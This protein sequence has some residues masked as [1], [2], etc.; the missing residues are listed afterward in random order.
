L[1]TSLFF[2][3]ILIFSSNLY[4]DINNDDGL[5][6]F[7]GVD[8]GF[9]N[10]NED[11]LEKRS[12]IH[13]Q[14]KADLSYYQP[15]MVFDFGFGWFYN[16]VDNA[17]VTTRTKSAFLEASARYR[18]NKKWNIGPIITAPIANDNSFASATQKN[19]SETFLGARVDF[20]P[21]FFR[22]NKVRLNAAIQRDISIS[23]RSVTFFTMGIQFGFPFK[24]EK[25][26]VVNKVVT[27]VVY[28]KKYIPSIVKVGKNRLRATF[29]RGSGFF[30]KTGSDK[31]NTVMVSY[32]E[33]LT[34]FL[35][36]YSKEWK[37]LEISGHTDDVGKFAYNMNLSKRRA[38]RVRSL[39]LSKGIP[40]HRLLAKWYGPK[41]PIDKRK[42]VAA[43]ARNRR[44]EIEFTGV[45]NIDSFYQGLSVIK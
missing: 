18:L 17:S 36:K 39:I 41:K 1:K 6:G 25:V 10:V 26:N 12:G 9:A 22:D 14:I 8:L 40:A 32:L 33:R 44:V 37:T 43:R 34:F 29:D 30:F 35:K 2:T 5:Y 42:T 38:N 23:E 20:E 15:S 28:E 31:A 11:N 7:A 16:E 13:A 24:N 19:S 27:K 4:A 45:K 21:D 3:L